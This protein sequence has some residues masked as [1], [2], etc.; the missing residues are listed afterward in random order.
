MS[1]CGTREIKKAFRAFELESPFFHPHPQPFLP[2]TAAPSGLGRF[3]RRAGEGGFVALH[4]WLEVLI[5][6]P[7]GARTARKVRF[8]VKK[9]SAKRSRP[10]V[11][12]GI[13]KLTDEGLQ[14]SYSPLLWR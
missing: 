1:P 11:R 3:S 14:A 7:T 6:L 10:K 12:F 2:L 5:L 13:K 8:M 9:V 4:V